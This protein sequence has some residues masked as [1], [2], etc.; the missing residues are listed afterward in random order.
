MSKK[1]KV[2]SLFISM[3]LLTGCQS[4]AAFND[5]TLILREI[6]AEEKEFTTTIQTEVTQLEGLPELE[7]AEYDGRDGISW[8]ASFVEGKPAEIHE[9]FMITHDALGNEISKTPV[10]G[11]KTEIPA[12][13]PKMQFGGSVSEG[14]VFYPTMLMYGV[15]CVGCNV[16]NGFGGTSAGVTIGM[17]S[18]K[19]PDGTIRE[20]IKYGDYYIVAADP[21]IPLCTTMTI[22]D[23]GISGEGIQPGVPFKAIVLDRGGSIKGN[24]LDLFKGSQGNPNISNNRRVNTK[25]VID[26]VGGKIA[27]GVC[28]V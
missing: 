20:G 18:V 2:W 6:N 14:S 26:R 10:I 24:I 21:S 8:I 5:E 1:L 25:V 23:H 4:T 27:R 19:Q 15:D 11:S 28:K 12:V 17:H 3:V 22:Y 13:A 16:N 9:D 7:Y